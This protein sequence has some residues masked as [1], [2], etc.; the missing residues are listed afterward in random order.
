MIT[1]S[2]AHP[3]LDRRNFLPSAS[4]TSSAGQRE[5]LLALNTVL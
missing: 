1:V 4:R 2:T 3:M 5:V